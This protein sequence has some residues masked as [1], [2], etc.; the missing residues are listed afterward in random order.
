MIGFA[1]GHQA[2]FRT[3]DLLAYA[4]GEGVLT[5]KNDVFQLAL[6]IAE[7]FSGENPEKEAPG[8]DYLAPVDL[9]L[10]VLDRI[11]KAFKSSLM[12]RISHML[13]KD[14]LDRPGAGDLLPPWQD[15]FL[16]AAEQ[17]DALNG[18]VL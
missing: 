2:R 9:D 11:P 10:G 7:L 3:P 12:D 6:V 14:P 8:R 17:A 18:R 1:A 5:N 16:A 15:L 13:A 4:K